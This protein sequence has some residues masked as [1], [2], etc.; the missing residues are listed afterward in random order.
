MYRTVAACLREFYAT[1]RRPPT[2][3]ELFNVAWPQFAEHTDW[4]RP[5]ERGPDQM[6]ANVATRLRG[7]RVAIFPACAM[8]RRPLKHAAPGSLRRDKTRR[9]MGLYLRASSLRIFTPIWSSTNT[10]SRRPDRFGQPPAS[11]PA[12]R[13][14][15]VKASTWLDQ[16]RA[17]EQMTWAPGEPIEIA[18]R[19]IADGGWIR[20]PGCRVFNLYRPPVIAP[21]AGDA[22]PGSPR[23]DNST[24]ATPST[25]S[26]GAPTACSGPHEKINHALVLGG[27][28]GIGKDTLLEPV[29]QAVGAV[30]FPRGVAAS[31]CSAGSTAF[32]SP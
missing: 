8:S 26:A 23:R 21:V 19:L 30:E 1:H 31:R 16:N 4:Q 32:S 24:A 17:V 27:K 22:A 25:S 6:I 2:P 13:V 18:D 29:K 5:P 3:E 12:F 20:R 7:K 28:Q 15:K 10:S 11:T 14:G 9:V